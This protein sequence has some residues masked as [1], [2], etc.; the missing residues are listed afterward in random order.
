MAKKKSWGI[1]LDTAK[2]AAKAS[3]RETTHSEPKKKVGRP[4]TVI[5][6]TAKVQIYEDARVLA[7]KV[8]AIEEVTMTDYMSDLIRRDA[9]A[10]GIK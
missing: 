7:K 2:D 10:K 4:K 8:S 1:N 6:K 3:I 9:A 5:E